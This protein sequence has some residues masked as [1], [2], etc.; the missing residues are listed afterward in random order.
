M[1]ALQTAAAET[2]DREDREH[3]TMFFHRH[4]ERFR[5]TNVRASEDFSRYRWTLDTDDDLKFLKALFATVPITP[6]RIPGFAELT[7]I[8]GKHPEIVAINA[9]VQQK[10]SSINR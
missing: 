6:N 7:D 10:I 8:L 1:S 9:N 5:M 2:D 3:V 4:P